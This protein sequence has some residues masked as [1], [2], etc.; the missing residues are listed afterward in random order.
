VGAATLDAPDEVCVGEEFE[1]DWSGPDGDGDLIT[2]AFPGAPPDIFDNSRQ[3]AEGNPA[4]LRAP[5]VPGTY[6]IRYVQSEPLGALARREIQVTDCIA[7][8]QTESC[9]LPRY[10]VESYAVVATG[11]QS[12]SG[13]QYPQQ[14]GFTL[15]QL[16]DV[17]DMVGPM[18]EDLLNR[19]QIPLDVPVDTIRN[20]I[21]NQLQSAR[22]TICPVEESSETEYWFTIT[23]AH[24]RMAMN[25]LPYSMDIHL[26]PGLGEGTMSMADH[27]KREVMQLTLK[28]N[29]DAVAQYATGTGW[30]DTVNMVPTG[31][32]GTRAGFSTSQYNFDY[33]AGLGVPGLGAMTEADVSSGAI[34]GPQVL[35]NLVSVKN[36]GTAWMAS[37]IPG[38]DIVKTFYQNLSREMQPD[39]GTTSFFGGLIQNLVG[40]LEHGVP[41]EIE[42]TVSSRIAGTTMVSGTSHALITGFEVIPLPPQWC[43]QSLMP[44]D[45]AVTDIDQQV[46][47]AMSGANAPSS[48]E[49]AE[50]M[51][52]YNEAMQQMTPEQRQMMEQFGLGGSQQA[53]A[54]NPAAQSAGA[55]AAASS[56]P[57][58]EELYSDNLTQ[59]VQNHLQALGYDPGTTNG[60]M[61]LETTIAISQF[62]AEQDLEVTGEVSPQLAGI[63]SAEVDRRRGN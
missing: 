17:S 3:T 36:E 53:P 49:M 8:T 30:S 10:P 25:T 43:T 50:A 2:I 19:V 22:N 29:I 16:C 23:Y 59:M 26:P 42:Q 37:C 47:E 48:A 14:Q 21:A 41:L 52:Q 32:S 1:V 24:C 44:T 60:E 40:M 55:A 39:Q 7:A 5:L 45:Y 38:V 62:Q 11:V 6:E 34:T 31:R 33:T 46:T 20:N 54:A 18:L 15:Q 4:S 27:S 13:E 51:Q 56:M 63:L 58:S 9:P 61:S 35:G 12:D 28:R 57:S